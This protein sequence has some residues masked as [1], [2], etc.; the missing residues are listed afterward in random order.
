MRPDRREAIE[1]LFVRYGEG[2]GSYVL[3]RVG[4][5]E[6]AEEITARVFCTAVRHFDRCHTSEVGWLWS[7]VRSELARHFRGR[8]PEPLPEDLL[9]PADNP[10]E[11]AVRRETQRSLQAALEQLDEDEQQIISLKYFL[12][13]RNTEI[14]AALGLSASNVGVKIH[15]AVKRLQEL[16]AINE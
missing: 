13:V 11:H 15:R 1:R 3:A 16:M 6:L 14:A 7:I 12:Q 5:A 10:A 4:D 2:V 9:D 8:R